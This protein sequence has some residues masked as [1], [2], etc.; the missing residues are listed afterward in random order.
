MKYTNKHNLSLLLA[1]WLIDD[2]YSNGSNLHPDK[3]LISVTSLLRSTRQVVLQKQL[4][5]STLE[6]DVS[7]NVSLRIGHAVHDSIEK[8]WKHKHQSILKKLGYPPHIYENIVINPTEPM[9]EHEIPIYLE[10]RYFKELDGIMISGQ[11]DQ[12]FDGTLSDVKTTSVWSYLSG[13]NTEKFKQ[14]LS[15]YRWLAPHIIKND[16]AYINYVFTGWESFKAEI[17]PKYP[18]SRAIA[19][20]IVLYSLEEIEDILRQKL[21]KIKEESVKDQIDMVQCSD[22]ELW[23]DLPKYKYYSDPTKTDGK[24]TKNFDSFKEATEHL[25]VKGK[26][27]VKIVEGTPKAC[28]FCNVFTICEQRKEYFNDDGL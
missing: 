25:S 3:E 12:I 11:V 22:E 8:T 2:D 26:G 4:D 24:S 10:Q 14:Q 21:K 27:T 7:D 16:V 17:D 6:N 18:Q 13:N 28:K 1:G 23:R 15:I 5:M 9:N 20:P 19:V